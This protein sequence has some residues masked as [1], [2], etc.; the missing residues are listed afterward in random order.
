M[1]FAN[2][3]LSVFGTASLAVFA[4]LAT[5]PAMAVG[6]EAG[7]SIANVATVDFEVGGI[8]QTPIE[9]SPTGNSTPGVNNGTPTTFV[10]DNRVDLTLLETDSQPTQVNPG[11]ANVVATFELSNTGNFVQ[12]FALTAANLTTGTDVHGNADTIDANNLRIFAD[13]DGSGT[14]TPAD[15]TFVDS[16]AADSS[17]LVFVVAD[18]PIGA[19]NGDFANVSATATVAVAGSG[20]AT[21]VTET[22]GGDTAGVD[23]VFGDAGNDGAETANDGYQVASAAFT[24]S[25]TQALISD[26]INGTTDPLS[27]PGAVVE[28]TV[29]IVNTGSVDADNV[30]LTDVIAAELAFLAGQYNGGAADIEYTVG[31]AT[32]FCTA[33]AGDTDADNCGLTGATLEA[34][35]GL[36]LGT[37]AADDT[38]VVRFQATIN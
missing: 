28:Y 22:A 38:L 27:I 10:V 37:T 2:K 36:T 15:Q 16:L 4:A 7:T 25:K 34:D 33:D 14:F 30:G 19:T 1:K 8:A 20:G 31:G 23:V 13:T 32:A 18:V 9:S 35:L 11:Q 29:T 3:P 21:L 12:D 26:P 6:T 5:Q 24:V 17:V